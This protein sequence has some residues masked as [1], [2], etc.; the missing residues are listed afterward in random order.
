M[1]PASV[2][3]LKN[4]SMCLLSVHLF[5]CMCHEIHMRTRKCREAILLMNKLETNL[6]ND[7]N[8]RREQEENKKRR[9]ELIFTISPKN[10]TTACKFMTGLE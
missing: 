2:S 8:E 4:R 3:T 10:I 1:K 5:S 7:I 6:E 9:G